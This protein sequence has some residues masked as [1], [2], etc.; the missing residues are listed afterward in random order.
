LEA[1]GADQ[2]VVL[3]VHDPAALDNAFRIPV[4]HLSALPMMVDYF[5]RQFDREGLS[6]ASPDI[7]GIKRAQQFREILAAR[8]GRRQRES[9]ERR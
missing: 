3:D 6:V 2:L 7:G 5:A 9:I 4:D 8:L 1:A